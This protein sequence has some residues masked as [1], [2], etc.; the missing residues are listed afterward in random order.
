MQFRAGVGV[1]GVRC[2]HTG[3]DATL[4]NTSAH[5]VVSH[6]FQSQTRP[7]V[8]VYARLAVLITPAVPA[9]D[10]HKAWMCKYTGWEKPSQQ[11]RE[12]GDS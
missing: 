9:A 4:R 8:I 12:S 3:D 2:H 6:H 11:Y 1:K 10:G 7:G 5:S